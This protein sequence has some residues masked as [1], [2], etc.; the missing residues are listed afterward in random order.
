[1]ETMCTGVPLL[2]SNCIGLKEVLRDTPSKMVSVGDPLALEQGIRKAMMEPW[3]AEAMEYAPIAARRFDVVT[4][5]G[6]LM[7]VFE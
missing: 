4:S 2:G 1:M 6:S 7:A 5:V 3:D